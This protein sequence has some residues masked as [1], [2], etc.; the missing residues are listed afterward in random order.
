MLGRLPALV[1][2]RVRGRRA[3]LPLPPVR[4]VLLTHDRDGTPRRH[5]PPATALAEVGRGTTITEPASSR[6]C[7]LARVVVTADLKEWSPPGHVV[8]WAGGVTLQLPPVR[9][10]A[11]ALSSRGASVRA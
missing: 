11:R 7:E 3:P 5:S 4:A 8:A 9:T 6:P 2:R 1:G 10:V